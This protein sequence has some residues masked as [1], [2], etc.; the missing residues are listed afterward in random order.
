MDQGKTY[1]QLVNKVL[2]RLREATTNDIDTQTDE[3]ILHV[4]DVL[5]EVKREVEDAW[6]WKAL[7]A[8]YTVTTSANVVTYTL[9]GAGA[10]VQFIDAWNYTDGALLVR[11]SE[12]WLNELYFGQ[13]NAQTGSPTIYVPNGYDASY[14]QNVDVWPKP[15]AAYTLKFNVYA[16]QADLSADGDVMLCPTG[17]V[18]EGTYLRM[19][20]ERGDDGGM[21]VQAQDAIYRTALADAIAVEAGT[22]PEEITWT[23]V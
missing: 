3:Y 9:T 13:Q 4:A 14:D 21:S 20:A 5:N 17:P 23:V 18:V 19:L 2:R 15:D 22:T 8:T 12:A 11:R 16:P 1:L 10:R 7:R 6:R